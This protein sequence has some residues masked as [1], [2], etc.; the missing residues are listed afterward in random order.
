MQRKHRRS[1]G[2]VAAAFGHTTTRWRAIAPRKPRSAQHRGNRPL[3]KQ[4]AA[5]GRRSHQRTRHKHRSSAQGGTPKH[6]STHHATAQAT[7]TAA[8]AIRCQELLATFEEVHDRLERH[9]PLAW[10]PCDLPTLDP[11]LDAVQ[12]RLLDDADTAETQPM[13]DEPWL[14]TTVAQHPSWPTLQRASW[15][16]LLRTLQGV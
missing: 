6:R 13:M 16:D 4:A 11:L 10:A 15:G 9:A 2:G 5:P 14:T 12:A 8:F 1:C 3:A 7:C